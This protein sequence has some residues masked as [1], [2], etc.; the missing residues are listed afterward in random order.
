MRFAKGKCWL[1][2][3]RSL[4]YFLLLGILL[5]MAVYKFFL[6]I[7]FLLAGDIPAEKFWYVLVTTSLGDFIS[8][9]G[10]SVPVL[11]FFT[12]KMSTAKLLCFAGDVPDRVKLFSL[13]LNSKKWKLEILFLVAL[14]GAMSSFLDF[15][16]Y[17]FIYGVI[18]L[19]VAMRFGF[20]TIILFNFY[21]LFITYLLPSIFD[22]GFNQSFILAIG[23][24]KM[25]LGSAL[26]FVFS[27]ITGRVMSD[28]GDVE[29]KLNQQN[30]EL[31]QTNKELDRFVYSVSHDLSAPLK[32]ILGLVN[33]GKI[34]GSRE[35]QFSYFGKIETSVKKL[36]VFIKEVL[37][38]SKNK[39]LE[40]VKEQIKLQE[41]CTEILDNLRYIDEFKNVKVDLNDLSGQEINN[42]RMRLKIILNNIL[43]N[44][45]K[46]QK[47]T[48]GHQPLI[49][50]S[51][52]KKANR[53]LINIQDN[54]EGIHPDV[55]NKI[56]NMFFRGHQ[57]SNGS[58]LGLYIAKE[59]AERM[60]GNISVES[61]Y[62]EGTTFTLELEDN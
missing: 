15:G 3:I 14:V 37:D 41:L 35:D 46:Y 20:G 55:K 7:V 47:K 50:V 59:A 2:D 11:Y 5:P 56:F 54:G 34:S 13:K 30:L 60:G 4:V 22:P 42:D 18:S 28:M 16:D 57:N 43:T 49:K 62:G 9:F 44:A 12:G 6:E 21:L 23:K 40:S 53:V 58:G 29:R 1:P 19:Y 33:I 48:P 51:S 38:Y 26:L 31:E 25:Q 32:S 36:E 61:E 39:R 17:W 8:V 45:I 24:L 52:V 10:F 27:T